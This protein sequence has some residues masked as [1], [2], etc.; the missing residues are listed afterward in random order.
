MV[1]A[2]LR[3]DTILVSVMHANNEIGVVNDVAGIGEICRDA[4]VLL[5]VDAAQGAGKVALDMEVMKID[6]LSMSAH[7]MYGPRVWAR[8]MCAASPCAARSANA[9]RRA[10]ARHAIG[11]AGFSSVGWV[12]RGGAHWREE[13]KA[14]PIAWRDSGSDSGTRS[15]TFPKC[16][17][18]V[19]AINVCPAR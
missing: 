9:R 1:K 11:H 5:H 14:E 7:K 4:G 2:A 13:M 17:L 12:W 19:T 16:T 15:V 3:E 18:T 6:L 8:C 10:R